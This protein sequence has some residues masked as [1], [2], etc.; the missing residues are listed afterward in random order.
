MCK[1]GEEKRREERR[2]NEEWK[3]IISAKRKTEE[4]KKSGGLKMKKMERRRNSCWRRRGELRGER[5]VEGKR[6]ERNVTWLQ[7]RLK[8]IFQMTI[9][10]DRLFC[11]YYWF[12]FSLN[13]DRGRHGFIR[14]CFALLCYVMSVSACLIGWNY[15]SFYFVIW[16]DTLNFLPSFLVEKKRGEKR[17]EGK[18]RWTE[19][20]VEEESK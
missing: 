5:T 1:W 8:E 13:L 19:W 3:R 20:K 11:F 16:R 12:V 7:N 14:L 2:N 17:R 6:N 18:K 4:E 15:L 10:L 9:F